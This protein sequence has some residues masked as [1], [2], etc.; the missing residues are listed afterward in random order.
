MR[1]EAGLSTL[2]IECAEQGHDVEE[3]MDQRS[4]ERAMLAERGLPEA[5]CA[6]Q[7]S[8]AEHSPGHAPD[9]DPQEGNA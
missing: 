9:E 8:S 5:P 4:I 7:H 1:I 2:E 6:H 3:I